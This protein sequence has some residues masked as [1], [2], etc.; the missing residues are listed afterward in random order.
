MTGDHRATDSAAALA[1]GSSTA[2]AA[3][4]QIIH[5]LSLVAEEQR[6]LARLERC[7]SDLRGIAAARVALV[8]CTDTELAEAHAWADRPSS[9]DS[10]PM[11]PA[12]EGGAS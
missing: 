1:A 4:R 11:L 8:E 5:L 2:D 7:L 9:T 10:A 3:V 6:V 12:S